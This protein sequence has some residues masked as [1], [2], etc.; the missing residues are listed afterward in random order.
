[1]IL[2]QKLDKTFKNISSVVRSCKNKIHKTH[3]PP[4]LSLSLERERSHNSGNQIIGVKKT[5]FGKLI[6]YKDMM[7]AQ[8][9]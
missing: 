6:D 3:L 7:C 2:C 1:M 5:D 8:I 9:V 4:S